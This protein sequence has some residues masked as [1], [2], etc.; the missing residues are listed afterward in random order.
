MEGPDFYRRLE[1]PADPRCKPS[2]D[3]DTH[4]EAGGRAI[5]AQG[6]GYS[7]KVRAKHNRHFSRSAVLD[8]VKQKVC[9][10][11]FDIVIEQRRVTSEDVLALAMAPGGG[12]A[13]RFKPE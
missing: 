11:R 2:S 4:A 13:I 5:F 8:G 1:V 6:V 10:Q 12:F 7:D 3:V 9:Q